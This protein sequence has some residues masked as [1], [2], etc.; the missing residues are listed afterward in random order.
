MELINSSWSKE[1]CGLAMVWNME[2]ISMAM[3]D[4]QFKQICFV[5]LSNCQG[6]VWVVSN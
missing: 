6:L 4:D 3:L 2:G 5:I 1:S